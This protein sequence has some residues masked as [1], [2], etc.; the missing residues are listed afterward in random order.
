MKKIFEFIIVLIIFY[1]VFAAFEKLAPLVFKEPQSIWTIL[2]AFIVSALV[3]ILYS[4][5]IRREIQQKVKG[6]IHSLKKELRI[7][8]GVIVEK[9]EEIKKA[10]S[11]KKDLI[12]EAEKS[13]PLE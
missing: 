1:G 12:E 4:F 11:F 9:E 10:Q 2:S 7:K 13:E 3:L 5:L 8:E 6:D